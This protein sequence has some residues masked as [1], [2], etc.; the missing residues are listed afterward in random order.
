MLSEEQIKAVLAKY[1][2]STKV[3]EDERAVE[4]TKRI[5]LELGR[6]AS[7][8]NE[9]EE[10]PEVDQA[11]LEMVRNWKAEDPDLSFWESFYSRFSDDPLKAIEYIGIRIENKSRRMREVRQS[12]KRN[13][14][15]TSQLEINQLLV[16]NPKQDS[17]SLWHALR[18]SPAVN[19]ELTDKNTQEIIFND[20]ERVARK[21]FKQRVT[22]ARKA[23]IN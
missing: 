9:T 12:P 7:G 22:R 18:K 20:G 5:I 4:V 14:P 6:L 23:L 15:K 19:Q 11:T 1:A 2:D 16:T 10:N 8:L 3:E 13:Q 21:S 17:N